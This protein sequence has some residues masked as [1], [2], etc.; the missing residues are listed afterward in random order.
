MQYNPIESPIED[1]VHSL[2]PLGDVALSFVASKCFRNVVS[3]PT[4]QILNSEFYF[5]ETYCHP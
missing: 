1:S 3:N 2:S 4:Q 5:S